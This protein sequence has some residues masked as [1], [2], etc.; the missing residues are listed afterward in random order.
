M[1]I[2]YWVI[3]VSI[4]NVWLLYRSYMIQRQEKSKLNLLEFQTSIAG[5]LCEAQKTSSHKRERP[6]TEAKAMD[7]IITRK[8]M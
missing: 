3:D 6:S 4:V 5:V 8:C 1:R 7:P 2:I